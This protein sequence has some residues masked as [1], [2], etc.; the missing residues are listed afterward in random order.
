M[1]LLIVR[2]ILVIGFVECT[3][4]LS[5][6]VYQNPLEWVATA[7]GN[8]AIDK[9]IS[10]QIKGQ[11]ETAVLQNTIAAQFKKIHEWEKKYSSYTKNVS[12]YASSLKA[13]S[14]IYDD[15][16]RIF[17]TLGNVKRACEKKSA[18]NFC[19]HTHEYTVY[20]NCCRICFSIYPDTEC[21]GER[22]R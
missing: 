18:R 16:L 11:T 3:V 21:S 5:A 22:R 1:K 13:A 12:G 6:Q 19:Y 17:I 7:E 2:L 15:A 4:E 14:C 20:G 9:E 10:S 8:D